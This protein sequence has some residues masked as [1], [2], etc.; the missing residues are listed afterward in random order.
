MTTENANHDTE[1][2][3]ALA[4][5]AELIRDKLVDAMIPGYQV[6]FDPDEAECAGAFIEDALTEQDAAESSDD[7]AE[8]L[9]DEPSFLDNEGPSRE[10]A[11]SIT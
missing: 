7:L 9:A 4:D 1:N 6:E 5:A 11:R 3:A 2:V 8:G 10:V